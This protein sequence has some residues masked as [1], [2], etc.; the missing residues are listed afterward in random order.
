MVLLVGTVLRCPEELTTPEDVGN[1]TISCIRS[2]DIGIRS[3]ICVTSNQTD[4][5][6]AKGI[7]MLYP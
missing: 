4:S 7:E 5:T 2:L 6:E 3:E 1:L